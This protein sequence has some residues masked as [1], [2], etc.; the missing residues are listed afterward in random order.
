M[1]MDFSAMTLEQMM[2][3]MGADCFPISDET[4]PL[5]R[6]GMLETDGLHHFRITQ[7][8][9]WGRKGIFVQQSVRVTDSYRL[10]H[11]RGQKGIVSGIRAIYSDADGVD[12]T[13]YV[14]ARRKAGQGC[15]DVKFP[16]MPGTYCFYRPDDL[17]VI[18]QTQQTRSGYFPEARA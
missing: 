2:M 1:A 16:D 17:V 11:M 12:E 6:C 10:A 3:L 15:V 18:Y 8:G 14:I 5:F 9:L 13:G 7:R 4:V